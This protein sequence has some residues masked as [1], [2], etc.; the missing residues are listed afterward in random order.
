MLA[1]NVPVI[2]LRPDAR[3]DSDL[4]REM[5]RRVSAVPGVDRVA[6][7]SNVPWRDGGNFGDGLQFSVE[8]R[9]RENGQ[10]DPRARFRNVSPGF[11][12]ALG[13][14]ILAGRDFN[15]DDRLGAEPVVIISARSRS[16][17][18]PARIRSI[19]T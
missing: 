18:S 10:D 19:A 14:P 9:T 3:T 6:L 16:S 4:Y 5:Q 17:C 11:F 7:G 1:V 2:V 8:G 15:D 12:A 13:I